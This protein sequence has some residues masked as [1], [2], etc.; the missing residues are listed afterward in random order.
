MSDKRS[1]EAD[2]LFV[3]ATSLAYMV[4]A[5]KEITI[6]E[7]AQIL[8][9]LGKMVSLGDLERSQL[10]E[11]TQDAFTYAVKTDIDQF[12]NAAVPHLSQ[13]QQVAIFANVYEVMLTDGRIRV[14]ETE[15]A[16]KFESHLELDY[17]T[18]RAIK[19]LIELKNDA[20][21]ITNPHHQANGNR[22]EFQAHI[23]PV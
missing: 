16:R 9:L 20:A 8:T 6:E 17:D 12:L 18:V 7:K 14:G 15:L 10:R 11:L 4:V 2:P 13:A 3:L 5:D 21:V 22:Y 23:A 19:E 1:R